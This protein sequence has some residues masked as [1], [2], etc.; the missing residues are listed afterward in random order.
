MRMGG[1]RAREIIYG[2]PFV[3]IQE[4]I[5][6]IC[7]PGVRQIVPTS[8]QRVPIHCRSVHGL[9]AVFGAAAPHPPSL[10]FVLII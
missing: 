3:C 10:S 6:S 8:L 4:D 9:T 2:E 5:N 1:M 7:S